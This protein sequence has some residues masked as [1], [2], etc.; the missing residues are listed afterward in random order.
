M[1]KG[2][3]WEEEGAALCRPLLARPRAPRRREQEGARE[4]ERW[5]E[6]QGHPASPR[7]EAEAREGGRREGEGE[8]EGER[9][10]ALE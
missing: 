10:G 6:L 2:G 5:E 8:G 4:A 3:R 9:R 1:G 7:S